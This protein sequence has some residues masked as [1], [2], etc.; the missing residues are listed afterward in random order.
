[1]KVARPFLLLPFLLL[2]SSS[3]LNERPNLSGAQT[4]NP[5]PTHC[6]RAE[7]PRQ[8]EFAYYSLRDG[9][10]STVFLVS[11][12]PKPL[13]FIMAIHSRSGQ[14]LLGPAMTIQPQ[15]KLALDLASL[16]ASLSADVTGD[17]AEGSISIYFNGTIMPLAGQLTMSNP[18]RRLVL[19][20]EMID[21]SPGLGLLP[22][23]LNGLWWGLGG[24]RD[25]RIMVTNT[26][27]EAST[28]DV[29]LDF[30][31][32]RHESARLVFTAHETKVLSIAELLGDLK[33]SP[34][35]APEG[36]ITIVPRG[37]NPP[38]VAQGKITDPASGFS[39]NLDFPDPALQRASAL[40]AAGVPIGKPTEDSPYAGTGSFTPHVVVR[41]LLARPQTVT[42]AIEYPQKDARWDSTKGPGLRRTAE[43]KSVAETPTGRDE[44]SASPENAGGDTGGATSSSETGSAAGPPPLPEPG[45]VTGWLVLPPLALGPHSTVDF[46]LDDVMGQLPLPLPFCSVRIQY[47][48]PPGSVVA[49]V[50]SIETKGDLVVDSRIA[51][52]GN[53]WAGSGGH[54]WHLDEE[55]ESILFLSNSSDKPARIGFSVGA[56]GVH[57]CLTQ[58]KLNPHETR[59]IDIRKLR[60]AQEADYRGRRIPAGATDG[61]VSWIRLDNVAVS[62]RMLVLTRHRGMASGYEC[63]YCD[64]PPNYIGLYINP[65]SATLA[66]GENRQ[67]R[68]YGIHQ[69]CNGWL[70]DF[71]VTY[72]DNVGSTA[73][74]S[75]SPSVATVG[76][77]LVH[78]LAGGS[79]TI[80]AH[81][82]GW[83]Y[84]SVY[85]YCQPAYLI[86]MSAYS[87]VAVVGISGPQTVWWFNGQTPSGYTTTIT[88]TALPSGASSYAWSLL[89][90]TDKAVLQNQSG[91]TI[92]LVGNDL[93]TSA[94][95]VTVQVSVTT[96]GGTKL[97]TR[98]VTVRGPWKLVPL[99]PPYDDQPNAERG[100]ASIARYEIQD[101]FSTR[102]P[103]SVPA[104]EEWTSSVSYDPPYSGANCTW[105]RGDEIGNQVDPSLFQDLM[106]GPLLIENPVP[107][108]T[109]PSGSGTAIF[110]WGKRFA[111]AVCRPARAHGS[112]PIFN[113]ST[114]ITGD[115]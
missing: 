111:L 41:N 78:A 112:R 102:L 5:P 59:A 67:F 75:Y 100:F 61:S 89:A 101:N 106:A 55:T 93:S 107:T 96:S 26:G 52:E 72:G 60:D 114:L 47:A 82:H 110:H 40:H 50:S 1:M 38:L 43:E 104:N 46:S 48:G 42:L 19:E 64:C 73:W 17:F 11:A 34:A 105:T 36:G 86:D 7:A 30:L 90:G 97:A 103:S 27:G 35:Q 25:G 15:E 62:G 74:S 80:Q 6:C 98:D 113:N 81:Y 71:D 66:V 77:G 4:D 63:W 69:D 12:S 70:W 31:G 49:L 20:S 68:A 85:G 33:V 57:Y 109:A 108:P 58:V 8:L 3:L 83:E 84:D 21:N 45:A 91:N 23:A 37:P 28:A 14:T 10:N 13:E 32:E 54:P 79:A 94:G 53:G 39:T 95:D 51:N 16:L 115:I 22:P 92:Q 65:G 9:F 2:M 88:L 24:G 87:T 99:T 56:N 29:Y 76:Y 44:S 18:A